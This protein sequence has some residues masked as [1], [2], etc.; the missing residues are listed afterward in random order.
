MQRSAIL[1]VGI[2]S[3][4]AEDQA[5]WLVAAEIAKSEL[6]SVTVRVLKKP[7]DLLDHLNSSDRIQQLHLIDACQCETESPLELRRIQWPT[8]CFDPK[9]ESSTHGFSLNNVLELAA[10]MEL[11]PQQVILWAIMFPQSAD[12][13]SDQPDLQ[14]RSETIAKQILESIAEPSAMETQRAQPPI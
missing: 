6:P 10:Q 3:P 1:V 12:E 8:D 14:S 5:G 11:L 13:T 9:P 7:L 2:G 4:H